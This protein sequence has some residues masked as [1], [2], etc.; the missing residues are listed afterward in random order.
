M[1]GTRDSQTTFNIAYWKYDLITGK[2]SQIKDIFDFQLKTNELLIASTIRENN[3]D[4]TILDTLK[5]L[6]LQLKNEL[7]HLNI[8][9]VS[10][11]IN[12][13]L[14]ITSPLLLAIVK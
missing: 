10:P 11:S 8:Q 4:Y 9:K 13:L 5:N 6:D 14:K 12:R 1:N 2:V 3:N 7:I